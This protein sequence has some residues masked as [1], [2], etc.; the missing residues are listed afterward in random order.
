MKIAPQKGVNSTFILSINRK[1]LWKLSNLT[2]CICIFNNQLWILIFLQFCLSPYNFWVYLYLSFF[3]F[4]LIFSIDKFK[5]SLCCSNLTLM[6]LRIRTTEQKGNA[7]IQKVFM[8]NRSCSPCYSLHSLKIS[9]ILNPK[10]E[11]S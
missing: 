9:N 5:L 4:L 10:I 11:K 8:K 3:Y 2:R 7:E 6:N 1:K